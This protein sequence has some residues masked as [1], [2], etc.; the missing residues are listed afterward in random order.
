[1]KPIMRRIAGLFSGV[2]ML[3]TLPACAQQSLPTPVPNTRVSLAEV[4]LD[5]P[6]LWRVADEDTTIYLFGTVHALPEGMDWYRGTI[7]DALASSD[8]LVTEILTDE[9]MAATMQQLVAEKAVLPEGQSLRALLDVNQRASYEKAVAG[10]G[11][12]AD[13]FDRFEPWYAAMMLSMLPLL[14]QGYTPDQGVEKILES[15]A[16]AGLGRGEL[17]TV[18]YQIALFDQLPM[19]S[20]ISF[21]AEV[22]DNFDKMKPM[23]DAMVAEWLEGDADG[24]AAL[25]NDS[26]TDPVLAEWLLYKR[27]RNW[28]GWIDRR[29]DQP[30]TVFI[31]VGAGHLA[32]EK[33]VQDALADRGI[34][35]ERVQ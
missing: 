15:R 2:A 6:A 23:I 30:G 8:M 10:L 4:E 5:G 29:L 19:E 22:A 7:S 17:E 31:A 1:M 3:A 11:L 28:A 12:P 33:S 18:D 34:Q 32:G 9:S 20:Q 26:M 24:L 21:L 16:G 27:N 14:Q 35:T 25:M 13:S